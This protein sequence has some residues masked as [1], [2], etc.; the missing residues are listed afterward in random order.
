MNKLVSLLAI[1]FLALAG[2]LSAQDRGPG[3]IPEVFFEATNAGTDILEGE[4]SFSFLVSARDMEC[5]V[6]GF[7]HNLL[8]PDT[9]EIVAAM[10]TPDVGLSITA[11][12]PPLDQAPFAET[13]G[14]VSRNFT[15]ARCVQTDDTARDVMIYELTFT[16]PTPLAVGSQITIE[17]RPMT[18]PFSQPVLICDGGVQQTSANIDTSITFEIVSATTPT[19][20]PSPTPTMTETPTPTTTMTR[21]PTPTQTM[22]PSCTPTPAPSPS[23]TMTPTATPTMTP[24]DTPTMTPTATPTPTVTPTETPDPFPYIEF[25]F[26]DDAEGWSYLLPG[27]FPDA[28][29]FHGDGALNIMTTSNTNSYSFWESPQFVIGGSS[30]ITGAAPD[31]DRLFRANWLIGSDVADIRLAPT[32]RMR[33]STASF[34]Q[35][36]V[37]VASSTGDAVFSPRVGEREYHQF[38]NQPENE[39]EFILDFEV[40]N[41]DP[42]D[43]PEAV[44]SLDFVSLEKISLAG[45]GEERDELTRDFSM[46]DFGWTFR[47]TT[48]LTSPNSRATTAGLSLSGATGKNADTTTFGFWG[49][50][51]AE[52]GV[53]FEGGRLY[54]FT[55]DVA[56]NA[57]PSQQ[58]EV[59]AFRLRMN[60]SSLNASAYTNIESTGTDPLV[61]LDGSPRTYHVWFEAPEVLDG[62]TAF[63]SFDYIYSDTSD[64]DSGI[65]VTL[66][67]LSVTS[68]GPDLTPQ[69]PVGTTLRLLKS[70]A[71]PVQSGDPLRLGLELLNNTTDIS[72]TK[73]RLSWPEGAGDLGSVP[74]GSAAWE[75]GGDVT[76]VVSPALD[77]SPAQDLTKQGHVYRTIT[78]ADLQGVTSFSSGMLVEFEYEPTTQGVFD[79]LLQGADLGDTLVGQDPIEILTVDTLIGFPVTPGIDPCLQAPGLCVSAGG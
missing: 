54:H 39:D 22:S 70:S 79:L 29:G 59:P 24:T 38:F 1:T 7:A 53:V 61:P 52:Q 71:G 47:D 32:V 67:N 77:Q 76:V 12:N 46:G 73:V 2:G 11:F 40:L 63:L 35:S 48:L 16:I 9:V 43:A 72:A 19:P 21:T 51:E 25:T 49:S 55:F 26:D 37:L 6:G 65:E 14:F 5:A 58:T 15:S 27:A 23:P 17:G 57:D 66:Q 78:A 13:A 42:T 31:D 10:D 41:F 64:N 33:A 68:M 3:P 60:D 30:R 45:F 34:Q 62:E 8:F 20:T 4:T 56:T 75:N 18:N 28:T 50:P 36:S 74:M 69:A 44:I